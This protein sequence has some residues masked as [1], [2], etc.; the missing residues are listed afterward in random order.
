MNNQQKL[1]LHVKPKSLS[2]A[3]P[4]NLNTDSVTKEA[5]R[6]HRLNYSNRLCRTNYDNIKI[7]RAIENSTGLLSDPAGIVINLSNKHFAE[8]VYK[9]WNKN[10]YFVPTIK[11]FNKELSDKEINYF[12]RRIKLKDNTFFRGNTK[13]TEQTEEVICEKPSNKKWA[14]NKNHRTM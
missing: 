7:R 10:F 8:D 11:K 2:Q 5:G 13:V 6:K 1:K 9:L 3:I 12:Y 14:S 4:K